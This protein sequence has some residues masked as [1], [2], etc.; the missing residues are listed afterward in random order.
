MLSWGL[1]LLA[2]GLVGAGALTLVPVPRKVPWRL[3]V[4]AGVFG[5]WLS[6][7]ALIVGA[8][9]WWLGDEARGLAVVTGASALVAAGLLGRPVGMA[10]WLKAKARGELD[11][12]DA[13]EIRRTRYPGGRV[14]AETKVFSDGLELDFYRAAGGGVSPCVV[15]VHGG[16]WDG[17]SRGQMPAWNHW[18]ARRGYA[19]AAVSY[20][21]APAHR[22]PAQRDDVR[23]A[24]CWLKAHARELKVDPDRLVL[25]GRS[26]GG[27]IA[28]NAAYTTEEPRV[29]GVVGL[30]APADLFLGYESGREDDALNSRRLLRQYLGGTPDEMPE[31]Y[32]DG[33]ATTHVSSGSPP[34]L[35]LHGKLDTLVWE[36]H[37]TRLAARLREAN[38][39]HAVIEVPWATHAFDYSLDGPG[40]WLTRYALERFLARVTRGG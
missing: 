38:V 5:H 26:A 28:L 33:S 37:T 3:A 27:Q 40:G 11:R 15:V 16:G 12:M 20:R 10:P 7:V 17:G 31:R 23:T 34:T 32:A 30:Y 36:R 1:L 18:L 24:L 9:A 14:A 19:V 21:L 29:C 4:A 13:P 2:V 39:P 25:L 8:V 22:W 35:L 6:I